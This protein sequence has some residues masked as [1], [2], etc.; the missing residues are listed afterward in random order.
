LLIGFEAVE[1]DRETWRKM[2]WPLELPLTSTN[3]QD[4][5]VCRVTMD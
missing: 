5:S 4:S 1:N 2:E 3:N